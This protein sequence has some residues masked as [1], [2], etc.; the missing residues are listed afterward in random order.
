[1]EGPGAVNA[2]MLQSK[3]DGFGLESSGERR[4]PMSD[5]HFSTN[6]GSSSS[7]FSTNGPV[8]I[9]VS[10]TRGGTGNHQ[11]YSL[12]TELQWVQCLKTSMR[13]SGDGERSGT[14]RVT[15]DRLLDGKGPGSIGSSMYPVP[16]RYSRSRALEGMEELRAELQIRSVAEVRYHCVAG[17]GVHTVTDYRKVAFLAQCH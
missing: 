4:Q 14:P 7:S 1:M 6:E 2:G 17:A 10:S 9:I 8:S 15:L 3:E 11:L 16:I 5:C 13:E 12:M